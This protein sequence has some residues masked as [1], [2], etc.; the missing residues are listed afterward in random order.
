MFRTDSFT[1][2]EA[3][4]HH[5]GS[6]AKDYEHTIRPGE[7]KLQLHEKQFQKIVDSLRKH[8]QLV[9]V[10][11]SEDGKTVTTEWVDRYADLGVKH[12]RVVPGGPT[13]A[14][15]ATLRSIVAAQGQRKDISLNSL[16][17]TEIQQT[18]PWA[19][20]MY[21]ELEAAKP[22]NGTKPPYFRRWFGDWRAHDTATRSNI[23]TVNTTSAVSKKAGNVINTDTGRKISWVAT[24]SQKQL[25]THRTRRFSWGSNTVL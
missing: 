8:H 10:V 2:E 17:D 20:Q 6:G 25:I 21:A 23:V 19:R 9:A 7:A 16:T 18:E 22:G 3:F 15:V 4:V 13:K 14:D 12:S 11:R 1:N 24:F 5:P